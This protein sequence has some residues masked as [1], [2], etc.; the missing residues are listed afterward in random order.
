MGLNSNS[1]YDIDYLYSSNG[2]SDA[3]V[4]LANGILLNA[5]SGNAIQFRVNNSEVARIDS[6]GNVGIGTTSPAFALDVR[7]TG[8]FTGLL[9]LNSGLNINSETFT[10]LTGNGLTL[11]SGSLA[12][13]LTAGVGTGGTASGSGLGFSSGSVG[14]VQGCSSGQ[15]LAWDES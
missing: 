10:D 9:T 11:S 6:G 14:L 2:S 5:K 12:L 1:I 13:I 8:R 3:Y 4:Q 15:V 7:G